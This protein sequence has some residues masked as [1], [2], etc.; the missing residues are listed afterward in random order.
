MTTSCPHVP[1]PRPPIPPT[2]L[3]DLGHG[4][5]AADRQ[6]GAHQTRR[7]ARLA[8]VL[9]GLLL[10]V[11]CGPEAPRPAE[12]PIDHDGRFIRQHGDRAGCDTCHGPDACSTCHRH[13]L[14]RDHAP[15]YAGLPHGY[16]A[17]F[18]PERCTT[19]HQPA[20]CA[21]CHAPR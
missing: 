9:A 17:R 16:D 10:Q 21:S 19:C 5:G 8:G 13:Q 7:Y 15:G 14:P 12:P 2:A 4:L 1:A 20:Q 3:G 18:A 6:A 11:G